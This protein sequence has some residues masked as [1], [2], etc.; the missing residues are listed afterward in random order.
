[1]KDGRDRRWHGRYKA[2]ARLRA[3]FARAATSSCASQALHHRAHGQERGDRDSWP[4][5]WCG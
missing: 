4:M 1:M 2:D 3:E 5:R